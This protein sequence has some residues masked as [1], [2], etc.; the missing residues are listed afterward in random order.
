MSVHI[1][2]KT[3]GASRGNPGPAAI[4]V[5][6]KSPDETILH[7]EYIGHKTNNEAEYIAIIDGLKIIDR[8]NWENSEIKILVYM[9]SKLVV[10]QLNNIWKVKNSR[11]RLLYNEAKILINKFDDVIIRYISREKNKEA[12]RLANEALDERDDK[13]EK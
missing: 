13:I 2:M 12:D 11:M 4:G 7:K 10:N 8:T 5:V 3:D 6:I 1:S 9:D